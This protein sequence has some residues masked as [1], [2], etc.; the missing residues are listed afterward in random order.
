MKQTVIPSFP[1][2]NKNIH[3]DSLKIPCKAA[4]MCIQTFKNKQGLGSHLNSCKYYQ[5][6]IFKEKS[7]VCP[8]ILIDKKLIQVRIL[9]LLLESLLLLLKM[10]NRE[11]LHLKIIFLLIFQKEQLQKEVLVKQG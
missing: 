1:T 11:I 2:G 4:P 6:K 3:E 7:G 5:E 10:I 9:G 8:V